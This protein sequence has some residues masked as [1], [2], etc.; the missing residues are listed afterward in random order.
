MIDWLIDL[1][2]YWSIDLNKINKCFFL[3]KSFVNNLLIKLNKS[4]ELN[5]INIRF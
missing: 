3:K 2:T 4:N 1:L 5:Q